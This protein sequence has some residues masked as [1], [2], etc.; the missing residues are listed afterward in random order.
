MPQLPFT[1]QSRVRRNPNEAAQP[2]NQA[3]ER[4]AP[5]PSPAAEAAVAPAPAGVEDTRTIYS[6]AQLQHRLRTQLERSYAQIW[7]AGELSN[8][9]V[10]RASGHAYFTLKDR[11]ASLAAVMFATHVS[12]LNFRPQD[13]MEVLAGGTVTVWA[14]GG[15]LQLSA[16]QLEPQG[17][18]ALQLE[19]EQRVAM[20]R[21]E[22]LTSDARKRPIPTHPRIVGVVTSRGSAAMKDILRTL[23]RRNPRVHV[24]LAF[25][26]VQGRDAAAHIAAALGTLDAHGECDVILLARGGGSAEDLWAFNEEAVARAIVACRVPVIT[27]IGHETD[28]NIADL[29]S[30][31]RTSTPTAAAE[32]ATPVRREVIQALDARQLRLHR[33]VD[34][35]MLAH[36]RRLERLSARLPKPNALL[37]PHMQSLDELSNRVERATQRRLAG[38]DRRLRPLENRLQAARPEAR[39][40]AI[41]RRLEALQLR[42]EHAG[43]PRRIAAERRALQEREAR[44]ARGLGPDVLALRHQR[45]QRLE[46]RLHGAAGRRIK[47]LQVL[48]GQTVARVESLSPLAVLARGY[49]LATTPQGALLK[50]TEGLRPGQTVQVRLGQ[51]RFEAEVTR[52]HPTSDHEVSDEG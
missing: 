36:S 14:K 30:D 16:T 51:G 18:G 10:N 29:V 9:S 40:Q 33:A 19:F 44:L 32:H 6:V 23:L 25:S 2:T 42:L 11:D 41:R 27:G 48:L 45:L 50:S 46:K 52:I 17:V 43:A 3:A 35:H 5:T 24:R 38:Y 15:R 31:L 4:P 28:T 34:R 7:V 37:Q 39:L 49:A 22:G 13:G 47:A 12:R 26:P 20:L 1:F 21:A 8:F